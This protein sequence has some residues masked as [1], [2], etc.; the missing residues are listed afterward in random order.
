VNARNPERAALDLF[1]RL[2]LR[3]PLAHAFEALGFP[4]EESWRVAARIKV[5]LLIEAKVFVAA[6]EAQVEKVA[7]A[8]KVA[9]PLIPVLSPGLWQ[10]PDVQWL[11]GAHE[12]AGHAY[13]VKESYEELL[14]WLQL[15][16]FCKLAAQSVPAR[17]RIQEIGKAIAEATTAAASA[18][19]RIDVLAE[20]GAEPEAAGGPHPP[21]VGECG[22]GKPA[23]GEAG[24][25]KVSDEAGETEASIPA[26]ERK[27]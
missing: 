17:S 18:S 9:A 11:T 22:D 15:P 25:T 14:W 27:R 16:A 6:E 5:A 1:D 23:V 8:R 26:P 24:A 2:R 7:Q 3:E 19:Y 20:S 21:A 4:N 12:D 10:D 13:F